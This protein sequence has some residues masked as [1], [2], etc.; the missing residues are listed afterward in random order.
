MFSRLTKKRGLVHFFFLLI[1]TLLTLL[2]FFRPAFNKGVLFYSDNIP[3]VLNMHSFEKS[4]DYLFTEKY[5][6]LTENPIYTVTFFIIEKFFF[7]ISLFF[8]KNIVSFLW[9]LLPSL[10]FNI[11]LYFVFFKFIRSKLVAFLQTLLFIFSLA[12]F[13]SLFMGGPLTIWSHIGSLIFFTSFVFY[14]Y[15]SKNRYLIFCV[16][17]TLLGTLNMAYFYCTLLTCL[18]FLVFYFTIYKINPI[19]FLKKK[20]F[21]IVALILVFLINSFWILPYILSSYK[22]IT[23]YGGSSDNLFLGRLLISTP[24]NN[25]QFAYAFRPE[26]TFSKPY[27]L[28]KS[29]VFKLASFSFLITSLFYLIAELKK[30]K[31]VIVLFCLFLAIFTISLGNNFPFWGLFTKIPGWF[32]LR[33][34]MRVILF[35]YFIFI[36]SL[37]YVLLKN[38]NSFK[39]FVIIY[40]CF[41][42]IV[43][44]KSDIFGFFSNSV[45]QKDYISVSEYLSKKENKNKPVLLL[46][47]FDWYVRYKWMSGN[48]F[49]PVVFEWLSENPIIMSFVGR[50]RVPDYFK[51]FL[52]SKIKKN[53]YAQYLGAGG[54]KYILLHKDGINF[55]YFRN[56]EIENLVNTKGI[57]KIISGSNLTLYEISDQYYYPTIYSSNNLEYKKINPTKYEISVSLKNKLDLIF[58]F[59]Y[60]SNWGI[61]MDR[62]NLNE[63]CQPLESRILPTMLKGKTST[64]K[65]IVC[66]SNQIFFETKDLS[67]ITKKPVFE[68]THQIANKYANKWVLDEQAIKNNFGKDYYTENPDGNINVNLVLFYRPQ[69]YFYVSIITSV[70]TC[71]G[72]VIYLV[73]DRKRGP[74]T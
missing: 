59:P 54:V 61:F 73:I 1:I 56:I 27:Y 36:L 51:V 42:A 58:N 70:L 35:T 16:L 46:P 47:E 30:N 33:D 24:L 55:N 34:Y 32:F 62:V 39:K 11:T 9:V 2:I 20:P 69:A 26:P 3:P 52:D 23:D 5:M 19:I 18:L 57:K 66:D 64:I 4:A 49:T 8:N 72:C 29:I 22:K 71:L 14:I 45:V 68:T 48:F 15:E 63:D 31:K 38:A 50:S 12:Y 17:A 40:I 28:Y 21:I 67:Y 65:N 7:V 43:F 53:S 60:N 25:F 37:G 74:I 6:G 13:D 41:N 10:F 44:F